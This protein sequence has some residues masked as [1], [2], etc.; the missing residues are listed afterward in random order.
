M[1]EKIFSKNKFTNTRLIFLYLIIPVILGFF[2]KVSAQEAIID[3]RCNR[4]QLLRTEADRLQLIHEQEK[5]GKVCAE[6]SLSEVCK[7]GS[8]GYEKDD[9]C[10][11]HLKYCYADN[12][13][14]EG[15]TQGQLVCL[16]LNYPAAG[17]STGIFGEGGLNFFDTDFILNKATL[18]AVIRMVLTVVF[19]AWVVY[20]FW[21][22]IVGFNLWLQAANSHDDAKKAKT[23]IV[24]SLVGAA[25][26][27]VAI[28]LTALIFRLAGYEEPFNFDPDIDRLFDVDCEGIRESAVE[29]ERY[30]LSCDLTIL[31]GQSTSLECDQDEKTKKAGETGCEFQCTKKEKIEKVEDSFGCWTSF[32]L[33][34]ERGERE[35]D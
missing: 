24:N 3:W 33:G 19:A 12:C 7:K 29:C 17:K 6:S 4:E 30:N 15:N 26:G 20:K 35:C 28:I 34:S 13:C 23:H 11:K 14:I 18:P 16:E 31:S 27:A 9:P 5:E 25:V 32:E 22:A 2:V 8:D 1:M 21:N 10:L